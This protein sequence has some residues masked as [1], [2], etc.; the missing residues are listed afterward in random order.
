VTKGDGEMEI[1]VQIMLPF[2][3]SVSTQVRPK[4]GMITDDFKKHVTIQRKKS[5]KVLDKVFAQKS[6]NSRATVVF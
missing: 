6:R 5:K 1:L 3:A 2:K 4:N